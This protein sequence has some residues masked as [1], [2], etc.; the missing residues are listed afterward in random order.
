M[1]QGRKNG[2]GLADC[3]STM[4]DILH[5]LNG[6]YDCNRLNRLNGLNGDDGCNGAHGLNGSH[7]ADGLNGESSFPKFFPSLLPKNLINF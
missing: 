6:E 2:V 5:R 1:Q 7:G 3:G 4:S